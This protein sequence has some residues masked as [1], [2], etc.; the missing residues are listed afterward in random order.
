MQALNKKTN[1]LL[2]LLLLTAF[3]PNLVRA[4]EGFTAGFGG[5]L[6]TADELYGVNLRVF[7]A[8][9]E[10]FCFGPE[11]S[12]FP[13]QDINNDV[14]KSITDLNINAHY[15]LEA[16]HNLGVYPLLGVNYT[17]EDERNVQNNAI[18]EKIE[19]IGINYGFGAHY[20][21]K[22]VFLFAE[23]KSIIGEL[24]AEFITAGIIFSLPK[25][26]KEKHESNEHS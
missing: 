5:A 2:L 4:Q 26:H 14:E 25:K 23:F 21:I 1:A 19:A 3:A 22:N 11:V 16:T 24:S 10:H 20:K 7:Y 15:I 18:S 9:N 13:F 17:I 6:E 12:I 8:I